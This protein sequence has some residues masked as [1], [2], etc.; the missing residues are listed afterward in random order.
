MKLTSGAEELAADD[1]AGPE[2]GDDTTIAQ[3]LV[4]A[5]PTAMKR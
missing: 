4:V 3:I 5:P 1:E 2:S